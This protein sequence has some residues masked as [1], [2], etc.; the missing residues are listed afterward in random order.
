MVGD[1]VDVEGVVE[2]KNEG[3]VFNCCGGKG[4]CVG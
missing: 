4:G 2:V 3:I 1:V